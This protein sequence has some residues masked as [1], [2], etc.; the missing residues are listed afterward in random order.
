[1]AREIM[2]DLASYQANLT[3]NDYRAIGATKAIVKVTESTN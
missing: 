3:A 1:M 2:I